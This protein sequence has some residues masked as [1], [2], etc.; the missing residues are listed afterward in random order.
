MKPS[1]FLGNVSFHSYPFLKF[2][3]KVV[4]QQHQDSQKASSANVDGDGNAKV[5]RNKLK[6]KRAV[7]R[8]LKFFRFKKKKEYERM[9]AEEKN[10]YKLL[11]VSSILKN[12]NL[13]ISTLSIVL[14]Q[15]AS[16]DS[17]ALP[18]HHHVFAISRYM[19]VFLISIF[20]LHMGCV[21]ILARRTRILSLHNSDM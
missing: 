9:T 1:P 13:H 5:K 18:L 12:F 19:F 15:R 2:N 20:M 6:G 4:E 21:Q 3:D 11:K 16:A 17:F 7:V 14:K 10:L 8:W